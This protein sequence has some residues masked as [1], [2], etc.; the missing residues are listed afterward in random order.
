MDELTTRSADQPRP[1]HRRPSASP[2]IDPKITEITDPRIEAKVDRRRFTCGLINWRTL[3]HHV[4]MWV[5][6][7]S[8]PYQMLAGLLTSLWWGNLRFDHPDC[9]YRRPNVV[10]SDACSTSGCYQRRH[11]SCR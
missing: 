8:A 6:A 2:I 5:P 3:G 1:E 7:N 11:G 4:G 9:C 10:N